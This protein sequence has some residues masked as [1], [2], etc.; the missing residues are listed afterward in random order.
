MLGWVG[1]G[2]FFL[3]GSVRIE[4][5]DLAGLERVLRYCARSPPLGSS[6]SSPSVP[7]GSYTICPSL[8]GG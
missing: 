4:A 6:A 7:T 8:C 3:D 1:A 2:G 5:E